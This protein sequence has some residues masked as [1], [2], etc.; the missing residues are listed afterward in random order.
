MGEVS[1]PLPRENPL[2]LGHEAAE[3]LLLRAYQSNRL[4]HAWLFSGPKGIG[5]ATLAF[6]FARFLLKGEGDGGLFG[7]A[8]SDLAVGPADPVFHRVASLGHGDFRVLERRADDR[9]RL[10]GVI[11]VDDVR[12][13]TAFLRMTPEEA[14]W[15]VL[16]VDAA[17]DL[18]PNAANALLKILEEPPDRAVLLL[19]THAPA[20]L[21]PTIRSRCCRLALAP[22]PEAMLSA[23]LEHYLPDAEPRQ[24]AELLQLAEGSIGR[25]LDLAES[26]GPALLAQVLE[27]LQDLPRLDLIRLQALAGRLAKAGDETAFRTGMSLLV[28]WIARFV[29][30]AETGTLPAEINEGEARLI[31]RLGGLHPLDRWIETWHDLRALLRRTQAVNLDR[32]HVVISAFQ[33]L[34]SPGTKH[35]LA[36]AGR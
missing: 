20:S 32:R 3:R 35:Y 2:L 9:G 36:A 13:D 27:L 22:L 19:V 25:A 17:D 10:R 5:K 21:L 15:R 8:P 30:A 31:A 34:E 1:W 23:L 12:R 16:V 14:G 26:G 24:R 4:P 11:P 6:R 18:N 7:E 28:W 29:R 33:M